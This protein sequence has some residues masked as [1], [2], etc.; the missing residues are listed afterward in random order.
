[1]NKIARLAAVAATVSLL[2]TLATPVLAGTS[3]QVF[4]SEGTTL[5]GTVL[6]QG[7]YKLIYKKNGS[8]DTFVVSLRRNG[9]TVATADGK[10]ERRDERQVG[11]I[12]YRPGTD[13]SRQIAE[14]RLAGTRSVIVIGG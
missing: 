1:M 3:S 4:V 2:L 5:G 13:G 8:K 14:V 6:E 9:K 7:F 12:A 11:G 10:R